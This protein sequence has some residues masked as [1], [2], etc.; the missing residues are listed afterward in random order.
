MHTAIHTRLARIHTIFHAIFT[1]AE[2]RADLGG[3]ITGQGVAWH[4]IDD[5]EALLQLH[6]TE[7]VMAGFSNCIQ[8]CLLEYLPARESSIRIAIDNT[9]WLDNTS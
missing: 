8:L 3:I 5:L 4:G 9:S 2:V 6:R 7:V 1:P